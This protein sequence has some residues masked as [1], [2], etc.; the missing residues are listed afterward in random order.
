ME[1][2]PKGPGGNATMPP[3][4]TSPVHPARRPAGFT[5][6]RETVTVSDIIIVIL[7]KASDAW[8]RDLGTWVLAT[9]LWFV[10]GYGIPFV[11]GLVPLGLRLAGD[12]GPT[13][14]ALATGLDIGVQ[15]LGAVIQG[16][17][18]MGFVAMGVLALH[19]KTAPIGA[20]FSQVHK[21]LKYLLQVLVIYVPWL[22]VIAAIA[23]VIV[24][25]SMGSIDLDMPLEQAL[26]AAGPALWSSCDRFGGQ[27]LHRDRG[28][29][30]VRVGGASLQR[31][32]GPRA[33]HRVFVANST[34]EAL[35]MPRCR[36][37]RLFD[38]GRL[39][40]ALRRRLS[41]W[42]PTRWLDLHCPVPRAPKRRRRTRPR[43][44]LHPRAR[45]LKL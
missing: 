11:I 9:V 34:R 8:Q 37:H 36:D 31:P 32:C 30:H 44:R 39:D 21:A 33:S 17:L 42:W 10:I 27:R 26:S 1:S 15:I 12:G 38:R 41:L 43:H 18:M 35:A 14:E 6:R 4:P 3:V 25:L 28:A 40:D 16:I 2:D 20:L 13:T 29:N 5:L 19:G 45:L 24:V 23:A 7:S 22:F